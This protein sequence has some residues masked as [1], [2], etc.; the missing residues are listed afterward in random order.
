MI[1]LF[2]RKSRQSSD[3]ISKSLYRVVVV[4]VVVVAV[5]IVIVVVRLFYAPLHP[6]SGW[7]PGTTTR[8]STIVILQPYGLTYSHLIS[9]EVLSNKVGNRGRFN[10]F[11][12]QKG[13]NNT[14]SISYS[15]KIACNMKSDLALL[16]LSAWLSQYMMTSSNGNI[17]RVTGH[18]CGE[19][20]GP[21]WIPRTKASDAGLWCFLWSAS[22]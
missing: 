2:L 8:F 10:N 20:T 15:F 12:R 22:D 1:V 16:L 6:S 7:K 5:V 17:F 19:F 18:F 21:R 9:A 11:T 3:F 14:E 4:V 13:H